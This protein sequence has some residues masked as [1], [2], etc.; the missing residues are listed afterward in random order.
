MAIS[1]SVF[2][3]SYIVIA[4]ERFPRQAVALLGA[5]ALVLLNVFPLQEALGLV[6]W[7]TIGLLF[8]MFIL[9]MILAESGFFGW[10]ASQIVIRL[11]YRPTYI[12]LVMPLVAAVLASLMDSVTVLV[13]LS[14]LTLRIARLIKVDP[15]SLITAEVC[16]SNTGGAATLIGNPPNVILGTMLGFNF[17]DFV[18]HSAP[19][20]FAATVV[21]IAVFYLFNR[22]MLQAAERELDVAQVLEREQGE[23][24]ANL[25]LLKIGLFF[26]L[27][28][29]FLL[30]THKLLPPGS[31]ISMSVATAAL[32]PALIA[33]L[34]GGKETHT[35]MRKIDME[36]LLFFIGLFVLVGALQ[37]TQFIAMLA[38]TIFGLARNSQMGLLAL[39]YWGAG[40]T[41]A[42]VDNIP[43]ALAMAYV[44]RD[45]PGIA[46]TQFLGLVVWTLALGVGMGG[47]MTPVG[48][49][50]NVVAYSY[51][52]HFMGKIGWWR[53]IKMTVPPTIAT[54][55][56]GFALLYL[57][58]LSGW[59]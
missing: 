57:K 39:L 56:V 17:N 55:L 2:V 59:Y 24:I 50:A 37:K 4:T 40:F 30:M 9:I 19:L 36:S 22:Q 49:S 35:I 33:M 13:F 47:N 25:R 7:E 51:L 45:T 1:L 41:S 3:I 8:G 26:F 6:D 53:W 29:I 32:L 43:M 42:I 48:A 34:V 28:A 5:V 15:I 12:F 10:F 20:A 44:V 31:G 54:M 23:T 11:R 58:H 21:L 18:V 38:E 27:L 52:E 14:P 46:G 16:A